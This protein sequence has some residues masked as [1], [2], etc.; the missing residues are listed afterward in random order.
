MPTG[1]VKGVND[2]GNPFTISYAANGSMSGVAGKDDEFEDS[3]KWWVK[4]NMFCRQY[5]TWLEGKKAC[6]RVTL[7]GGQINWH[8][9][10]GGFVSADT[11]AR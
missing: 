10:V 4:G 1:K 5:K 8:D 11:F 6:F 2:Y 7:R 3:G 9:T